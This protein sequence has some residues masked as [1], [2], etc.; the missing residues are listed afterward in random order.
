MA[1]NK[2]NCKTHSKA[3]QATYVNMPHTKRKKTST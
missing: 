1:K 2:V 3:V